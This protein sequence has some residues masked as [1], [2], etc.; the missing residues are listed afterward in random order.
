MVV[1]CGR[2]STRTSTS[3]STSTSVSAAGASTLANAA[4]RSRRRPGAA[5]VCLVA[6]AALAGATGMAGLTGCTPHDPA[7]TPTSAQLSGSPQDAPH[8]TQP[9][10][11]D[12]ARRRPRQAN[13]TA[14]AAAPTLPNAPDANGQAGVPV[15][16]AGQYR[17]TLA[18][19]EHLLCTIGNTDDEVLLDCL[20]DFPVRWKKQNQPWPQANRLI[21]RATDSGLVD[22]AAADVGAA[23][24]ATP[25]GDFQ[26]LPAQEVV[27]GG[28]QVSTAVPHEA[29]IG[30]VTI[31]PDSYAV[32]Q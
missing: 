28:Q 22:E 24:G 14:P 9:G 11:P 7:T 12:S 32:A 16:P 4:P 10:T 26:D 3:A 6:A 23:H 17:L 5:A 13:P 30:A 15:L 20:P 29:R 18:A 1:H 25:P 2:T 31:T 8:P 19:D 21:V 27:I